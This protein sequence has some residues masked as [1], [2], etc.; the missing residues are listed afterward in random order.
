MKN[1]GSGQTFLTDGD[2]QLFMDF[3]GISYRN[4]VMKENMVREECEYQASLL[5][6]RLFKNLI[7]VLD[8]YGKPVIISE[9]TTLIEEV[10]GG[11]R[12]MVRFTV[13]PCTLA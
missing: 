9:I 10:F 1:P 5:K 6:E 4:L 2:E 3:R 7:R 11:A 12:V 8:E 13:K